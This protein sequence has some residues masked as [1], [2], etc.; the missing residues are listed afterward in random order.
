MCPHIILSSRLAVWSE[1]TNSLLLGWTR[2]ILQTSFEK[3]NFVPPP[4]PALEAY[5]TKDKSRKAVSIVALIFHTTSDCTPL[6]P[7]RVV[8]PSEVKSKRWKRWQLRTLWS[9]QRSMKTYQRRITMAIEFSG[10]RRRVHV[11]FRLVHRSIHQD[12]Q[13]LVSLLSMLGRH[14]VG[15]VVIQTGTSDEFSI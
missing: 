9:T 5:N 4:H 1:A 14:D 13:L 12:R 11:E 15:H 3:E 6:C 7:A 10:T 2:Y 8:F